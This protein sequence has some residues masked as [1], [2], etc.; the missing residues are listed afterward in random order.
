MLDRSCRRCGESLRVPAP[1][2]RPATAKLGG[3][4]TDE[5][6]DPEILE[7]RPNGRSKEEGM[8]TME[9]ACG[10][11]LEARD[12][13]ALFERV[14]EHMDREHPE[15]GIED[16]QVRN[17]IEATAHDAGDEGLT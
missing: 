15:K 2:V 1:G 5:G 17:L 11:R 13:E 16:E 8:R 3:E 12:D 6:V 7:T 4:P 14:R 9:C 10:E